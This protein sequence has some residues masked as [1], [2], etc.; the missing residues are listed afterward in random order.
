MVVD[1]NYLDNLDS[2]LDEQTIG[3]IIL[4]LKKFKDHF[5]VTDQQNKIN[6]NN[7]NK[8]ISIH[9]MNHVI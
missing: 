6:L 5:D 9:D 2:E 4:D 1:L 7:N 8:I 3:K